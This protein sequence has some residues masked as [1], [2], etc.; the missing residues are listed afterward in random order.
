MTRPS[1]HILL[2]EDDEEDFL[3]TGKLLRSSDRTAFEVKWVSNAAAAL[4]ELHNPYDACLVD[5]RLGADSVSWRANDRA[6]A[7]GCGGPL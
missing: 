6:V 7:S 5:Y 4:D 3:L 1:L 2:V